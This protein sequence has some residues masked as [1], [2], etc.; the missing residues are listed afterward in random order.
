MSFETGTK[1][2]V[3]DAARSFVQRYLYDRPFTRLAREVLNRVPGWT[4]DDAR[5]FRRLVIR[6]LIQLNDATLQ[7]GGAT[8]TLEGG[9]PAQQGSPKTYR[10]DKLPF[11][12]VVTVVRESR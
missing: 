2:D 9:Q 4:D 7:N 6:E 5:E 8:L 11:L 12:P 3:A 10:T 1:P